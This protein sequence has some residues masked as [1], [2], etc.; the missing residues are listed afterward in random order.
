MKNFIILHG[1]FGSKDGNWF[2]WLKSQITQRGYHCSLAQF[3][4]GGGKQSYKS[5]AQAI[6]AFD[7]NEHTTIFAHSAAPIFVVKYLMQNNKKIDKLIAVAGF[8]ALVG[9]PNYDEVNS[10]FLM[11]EIRNF[12]AH[13]NNRVCIFAD[14]DPYVPFA[15]AEKF[16]DDICAEKVI[17]KGGKHLNTD[18]GYTKFEKLLEYI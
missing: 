7:I 4:V 12:D 10:T 14:D 17:V 5:W 15:Y 9:E 1:S 16:A 2:P 3:P 11:D 8:N 13:C 6:N 18:S